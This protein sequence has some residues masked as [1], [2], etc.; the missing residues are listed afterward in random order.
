MC[1][2]REGLAAGEKVGSRLKPST[3]Q[4]F[5]GAAHNRFEHSL[6]TC[7]LSNRVLHHLM[8]VSAKTNEPLDVEP[9]DQV[10]ARGRFLYDRAP[11]HADDRLPQV[12]LAGLC[13]D[14]G[15]GPFSHVFDNEFLPRRFHATGQVGGPRHGDNTTPWTHEARAGARPRARRRGARLPQRT[16]RSARARAAGHVGRAFGAS[17]G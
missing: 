13:H 11:S 16:R 14:L 7:H 15:H 1:W 4:V 17:C 8:R 10:A 2:R 9:E 12:M 3:A 5:P 6:G